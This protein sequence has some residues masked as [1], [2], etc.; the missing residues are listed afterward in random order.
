MI[1]DMLKKFLTSPRFSKEKYTEEVK[2]RFIALQ[3]GVR[4]LDADS[5]TSAAE[6]EKNLSSLIRKEKQQQFSVDINTYPHGLGVGGMGK[7]TVVK[8]EGIL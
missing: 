6:H 8:Y 3:S 2:N 5:S 4:M 7:H 1:A